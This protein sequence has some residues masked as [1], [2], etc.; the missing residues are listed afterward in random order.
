MQEFEEI[1]RIEKKEKERLEQE[2]WKKQ[3]AEKVEKE[4]Q[5]VVHT[6]TYIVVGW[7]VML[8]GGAVLI[9]SGL[10]YFS[11][12]KPLIELPTRAIFGALVGLTLLSWG[13]SIRRG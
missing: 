5:R 1:E 8:I 13:I 11:L 12:P 7:V 10:E 3:Q 2:L 4:L 6:D 9:A